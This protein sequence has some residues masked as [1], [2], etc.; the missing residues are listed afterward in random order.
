LVAVFPN[1]SSA[2]TVN[3]K[4]APAVA[5]IGAVTRN[6]AAD[7]AVT[8]IALLAPVMLL[9]VVPVAVTV[10]EPAVFKV[11][12]NTPWPAANA[13]PAGEK[14][15]MLSELESATVPV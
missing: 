5:L 8:R 3:W 14:L 7:A 4:P 12:V 2:V 9:L 11:T 13:L 6:L 15:A 1:W 10:C